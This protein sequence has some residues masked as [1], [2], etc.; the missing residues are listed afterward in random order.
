M[1][2]GGYMKIELEISDNN[3]ATSSPYWLIIDPRQNFK[4]D[5][6][7]IVNIVSMITGPFFSRE[8]A[9]HVLYVRNHH[10]SKNASVY[11]CSGYNTIQYATKVHF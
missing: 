9:E 11:C 5:D 10:Y 8:E 1:D 2:N 4:K 3:E 6:D 7:G